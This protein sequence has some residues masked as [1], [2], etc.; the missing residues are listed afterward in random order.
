MWAV[1]YLPLTTNRLAQNMATRAMA[2]HSIVA[3]WL[4]SV[5]EGPEQKRAGS[6]GRGRS[7]LDGECHAWHMM[8]WDVTNRR[9]ALC[10][11]RHDRSC[12]LHRSRFRGQAVRGR[13][14]CDVHKTLEA[15]LPGADNSRERHLAKPAGVPCFITWL[16]LKRRCKWVAACNAHL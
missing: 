11:G 7:L 14:A 13:Q 5:T 6:E 10:C 3:A 9:E 1:S 2:E 8:R 12:P 16:Q 15:M 4:G